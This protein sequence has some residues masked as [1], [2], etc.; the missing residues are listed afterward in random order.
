MWQEKGLI[1]N[2]QVQDVLRSMKER[3]DVLSLAEGCSSYSQ[4]NY[5]AQ[6][7]MLSVTWMF[8]QQ[9]YVKQRKVGDLDESSRL[10]GGKNVGQ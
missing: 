1:F 6:K 3:S 9:Q 4:Q 2:L 5:R 8:G 10:G 7:V